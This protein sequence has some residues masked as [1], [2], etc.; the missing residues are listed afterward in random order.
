MTEKTYL[1]NSSPWVYETK[2]LNYKTYADI[3]TDYNPNRDKACDTSTNN[4]FQKDIDLVQYPLLVKDILN[5][6]NAYFKKQELNYTAHTVDAAWWVVYNKGGFQS[7][8]QHLRGT[9]DAYVKLLKDAN[10][11]IM[12][13]VVCYDTIRNNS[14]SRD[15]WGRF[16]GVCGGRYFEYASTAGAMWLFDARTFHGVYPTNNTRRVLSFD[17]FYSLN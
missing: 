9:E 11:G 1:P 6:I 17:I 2:F 12:S 8:H 15:E 13:A 14:S 10:E 4:G 7:L 5:E 16:Y 3:F